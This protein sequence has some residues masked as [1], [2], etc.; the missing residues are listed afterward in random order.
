MHPAWFL[1]PTLVCGTAAAL[2]ILFTA[3]DL[4]DGTLPTRRRH[5]AAIAA[6][7]VSASP[8]AL[9]LHRSL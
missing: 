6:S 2:G 9:W 1:A 4:R 8:I 7:F 5:R 3:W